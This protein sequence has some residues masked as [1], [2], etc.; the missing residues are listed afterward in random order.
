MPRG[1]CSRSGGLPDTPRGSEGRRRAR[2]GFA[3]R[4]TRRDPTSRPVPWDRLK[5]GV[6]HGEHT[7]RGALTHTR[8]HVLSQQG[9]HDGGGRNHILHVCA[10]PRR[11]ENSVGIAGSSHESEYIPTKSTPFPD[12]TKL[13]IA[14]TATRSLPQPGGPL[15]SRTEPRLRPPP[16]RSSRGGQEV[17]YALS[18]APIIEA[19]D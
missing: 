1:T 12:A 19:A 16:R 14:S 8:V 6:N 17:E 3:A 9:S 2:Q 5:E 15:I 4:G 18:L 7:I 11:A 10:Q 13:L